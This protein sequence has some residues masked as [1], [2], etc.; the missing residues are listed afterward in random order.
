MN[1]LIKTINDNRNDINENICNEL[2]DLINN[3]NILDEDSLKIYE[4]KY[5]STSNLLDRVNGYYNEYKTDTTHFDYLDSL[6]MVMLEKYSKSLEEESDPL[7]KC[8][9]LILIYDL[10]EW[11]LYFPYEAF[12]LIKCKKL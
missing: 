3:H 2:I 4:D 8:K 11:Q 7:I 5:F 6:D 1:D 10:L 12:E 9:Y